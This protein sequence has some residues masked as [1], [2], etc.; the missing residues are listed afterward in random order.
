MIQDKKLDGEL[1]GL[2]Y[3]RYKEWDAI[4]LRCVNRNPGV[5]PERIQAALIHAALAWLSRGTKQGLSFRKNADDLECAI[6]ILQRF[7]ISTL[8]AE[9]MRDEQI[10]FAQYCELLTKNLTYF[11]CLGHMFRY[12]ELSLPTGRQANE[13]WGIVVSTVAKVAPKALDGFRRNYTDD[14]ARRAMKGG[15]RLTP[16]RPCKTHPQKL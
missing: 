7:N 16:F 9:K 8:D 5:D 15:Y 1:R 14:E 12:F 3:D 2:I 11:Y 6:N 4:A 10:E 13:A